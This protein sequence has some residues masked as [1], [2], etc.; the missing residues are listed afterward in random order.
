MPDN[1][2]WLTLENIFMIDDL[3]CANLTIMRYLSPHIIDQEWLCEVVFVVRVWHSLEVQGHSGSWFYI[4]KFVATCSGVHV[5]VEES[6]GILSILGEKWIVKTL[7]ELLII[8]NDMVSLWCK[9]FTDGVIGEDSVKNKDLINRWLLP[10]ISDTSC[11]NHGEES[12]MNFPDECIW[13]HVCW[14]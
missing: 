13:H 12:T 14:E 10:L 7:I 4:T 5:W 1:I 2:D 8:V 9:E 3:L 6:S 11:S